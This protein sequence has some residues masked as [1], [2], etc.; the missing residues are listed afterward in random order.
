MTKVLELRRLSDDL[1]Y[2]FHYV[3]QNEGYSYQRED[4][5]VFLSWR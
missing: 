5:E 1:V 4:Q 3:T 2:R